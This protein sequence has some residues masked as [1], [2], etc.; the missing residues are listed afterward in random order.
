MGN[1]KGQI[2]GGNFDSI[3]IRQKKG[4][5]LE[6]GELLVSEIEDKKI[7]FKVV[8]LR[9]SSQV[10]QSNI[11]YI[12]GMKIEENTDFLM[13]DEDIRYYTIAELKSILAVDKKDTK[14]NKKLPGFF[15][16][17]RGITGEDIDFMVI[18]KNPLFIGKLRSGSR[19]L[20]IDL[21]LN[22]K[23]VLSHHV[24]VAATTGR[25]KSNL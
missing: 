8:D 10:S 2:I 15:S 17:I 13:M 22:G 5:K 12:S 24:L 6:I 21:F 7:L 11:E 23:D 1:I 16:N 14:L 9:Y 18:P 19:T 20:P 4:Q 3:L 25:G